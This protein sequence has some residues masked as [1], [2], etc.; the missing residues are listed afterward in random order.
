MYTRT[1]GRGSR[2]LLERI[3][4]ALAATGIHPNYLTLLGLVVNTAAAVFFAAGEFRWAAAVIFLA[5][6]LDIADGQVARKQGRVT[7]FGAFFDS[8][9]PAHASSPIW[10]SPTRKKN[11][12]A[13]GALND[14]AASGNPWIMLCGLPSRGNHVAHTCAGSPCG[15]LAQ[16][17]RPRPGFISR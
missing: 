17:P 2:W 15:C 5:G 11:G 6:F 8:S 16:P 9:R 1:I 3:V 7:A 10:F 4:A 14:S 12:L 13:P